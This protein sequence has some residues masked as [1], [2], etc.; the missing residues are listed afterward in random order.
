MLQDTH[1]Y[2]GTYVISLMELLCQSLFLD[3]SLLS[4]LFIFL[5]LS[6]FSSFLL[7]PSLFLILLSLL[8][9]VPSLLFYLEY[10]AEIRRS[11]ERVV[12]VHKL[13]IK[14]RVIILN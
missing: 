9:T 4:P 3:L 2:V 6:S 8:V 12:Q 1:V 13:G 5:P 11:R 7:L 14:K 10:L